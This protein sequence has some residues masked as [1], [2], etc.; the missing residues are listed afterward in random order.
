MSSNKNLVKHILICSKVIAII[1]F[2][3]N[4][5]QSLLNYSINIRLIRTF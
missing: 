2:K 4:D 1:V 5:G 3:C